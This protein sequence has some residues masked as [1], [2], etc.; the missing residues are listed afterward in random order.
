MIKLMIIPQIG[1]FPNLRDTVDKLMDPPTNDQLDSIERILTE[2][3]LL[4]KD[5]DLITIGKYLGSF[6]SLPFSLA[7]SLFY[8]YRHHLLKPMTIIVSFLETLKYKPSNL[9]MDKPPDMKQYL[10]NSG[11]HISLYLLYQHYFSLDEKERRKW[12]RK[13]NLNERAFQK[14][15]I[16]AKQYYHQILRIMKAEQD[17]GREM[18]I[19]NVEEK[20]LEILKAS[21]F[22]QRVVGGRS[23]FPKERVS[24][25]ISKNSL[26]RLKRK[27][28]D[29]WNGIY[30]DLNSVFGNWEFSVVS[31]F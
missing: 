16:N 18:E 25:D 8:S 20:L 28:P 13:Y 19:E 11:D 21:H 30:N 22:H 17:G 15:D 2:H 27:V 23:V 26:V 5:G 3:K 9:F 7:L 10:H 1:G 29:R 6:T 4:N 14:T 24:A 12:T 31:I